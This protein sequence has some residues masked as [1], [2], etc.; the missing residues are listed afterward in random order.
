MQ[1]R[2]TEHSVMPVASAQIAVTNPRMGH[3]RDDENPAEFK[4]VPNVHRYD[5]GHLKDSIKASID[6]N[7][8]KKSQTVQLTVACVATIL[9][10]VSV[11]GS[12]V[13]AHRPT[14]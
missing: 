7:A 14:S 10:A 2:A 12:M 4:T 1:L 3:V 9:S 6:V 5:F 8:A 13:S 11:V